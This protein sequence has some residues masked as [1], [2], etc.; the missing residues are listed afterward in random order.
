MSNLTI[1]EKLELRAPVDRVWAFLLAPEKVVACLPGAALD[2]VVDARTFR[3]NVKVKVGPVAMTYAGKAS[4]T[5]VDEATHTVTIL[6]EGKEKAGSD[7]VSMT[8]R[9][10]VEPLAAGGSE[11]SVS[12]DVML[13]GK[14]VRFGRG[15]IQ[16]VSAQLFKD[17]AA[18]I[19]T[20]L[21]V[22]APVAP[23]VPDSQ[24]PHEP[25]ESQEPPSHGA[26]AA[27]SPAAAPS[28][29]P[30]RPLVKNEPV[31]AIGL[32]FRT[33]WSGITRFVRRLVAR[34]NA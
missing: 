6:G 8:M 21:E 34:R 25:R 15:M 1:E 4:M 30:A 23:A 24:G 16:A 20:E 22:E 14:I 33:L 29:G 5:E 3:G 12:A 31:G 19:R 17:F 26:P 7:V 27:A 32:L 10:H 13:T 9:G 2:E 18:R 11:L 28:A